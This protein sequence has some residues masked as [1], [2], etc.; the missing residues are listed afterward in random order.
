MK[1]GLPFGC[2]LWI[3]VLT[4]FAI[5]D[6]GWFSLYLVGIIL[7]LIICYEFF[8]E[9]EETLMKLYGKRAVRN[10]KV[11]LKLI[12]K[13]KK[14]KRKSRFVKDEE[15]AMR[16]YSLMNNIPYNIF[17][18]WMDCVKDV[19][20]KKLEPL[21]KDSVKYPNEIIIR[22]VDDTVKVLL[23]LRLA[24]GSDP[25]L[26]QEVMDRA[27]RW[28]LSFQCKEGGFAAFDK[29]VT[30]PWLE[31]V[32]FSDHNAILD[33][34]CS[35]ITGRVLEYV[36]K[37]NYPLDSSVLK[38]IIDYMKST[39]E[40]DGS[41]WGRWG[42][43]YI[44][45]TWQALRGLAAVK[46]DMNQEWVMRS[47]DWLESCQNPDGGWGE[48]P[49]SY[50]HVCLKGQGTSTATQTAWAV[51]GI[52]SFGDPTR[53]SVKTGIQFLI[54]TQ[55]SDGT[56]NGDQYT[57][58]GFPKVYYMR[59]DYYRMNWPLIALSEYREALKNWKERRP[60]I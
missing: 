23:G 45:G 35:D 44:Y 25:V 9:G 15:M 56:W 16:E 34:P 26:Q 1:Q 40:D 11:K 24:Q 49:G 32:P 7:I 60:I 6:M 41:W 29:D 39:Q 47:R 19:K 55:Y 21:V 54:N 43:N 36:G 33:P 48:T 28:A 42:V 50:D 53:P 12:R 8:D 5:V 2:S 20:R 18:R 4:I 13:F 31:K 17:S 46:V 52:L 38:R 14:F 22:Y 58:T 57:G 10:A 3:L 30:K 51:M 59:Y 27:V 37:A